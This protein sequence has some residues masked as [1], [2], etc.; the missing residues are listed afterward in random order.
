MM[1]PSH[2]LMTAA[3]AALLRWRGVDVRTVPLLLGSV[4]PDLPLYVLSAGYIGW[5]YFLAPTLLGVAAPAEHV[6]GAGYDTNYFTNPWWIASHN[7]LHAPLI[8]LALGLLAGWAQ[9]S[10]RSWGAP[11]LWFVAGCAVHAAVD[12]ATHRDDG[13]LLF[14][15][16]DW[17][18]RFP[19]PISYWDR[20]YGGA[21]FAPIER[22]FDVMIVL[23]LGAGWLRGRLAHWRAGR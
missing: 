7:A 18:Y 9:R 1:T 5:N 6:F 4:L 3:G 22:A 11:L 16:V 19:A 23:A 12:I 2:F 20:R 10:G 17:S 21:I 14:F 13:P 15:P 8:L